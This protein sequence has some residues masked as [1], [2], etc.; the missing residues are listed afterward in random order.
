MA[1]LSGVA[2]LL[3]LVASACS[4]EA[5]KDP[6]DDKYSAIV[7]CEEM[8]KDRLK[9]PSTADFSAE[10]A[11]LRAGRWKVSGVV[12]SENSFG[13]KI[14][15]TFRCTGLRTTDGENWHADNVAVH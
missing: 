8:T 14:R 10:Q 13:A 6:N 9:A 5:P 15:G 12:D 3:V 4:A 2:C 1:K 11:V 7:M